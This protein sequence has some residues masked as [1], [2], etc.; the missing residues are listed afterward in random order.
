KMAFGFR[1]VFGVL[2]VLAATPAFA[3]SDS[4][5]PPVPRAAP[6][7]VVSEE[8]LPRAGGV[9]VFGGTA[10]TGLEAVKELLHR[11]EKV[12]VVAPA[13]ADT[14]AVKQLGANVI[15]GDALSPE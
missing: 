6:R 1:C 8:M 3:Q 13:S 2:G 12:S 4:T 15:A 5:E 7:S 10:G 9:I 14:T 11:G